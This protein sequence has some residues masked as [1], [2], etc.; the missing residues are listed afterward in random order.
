MGYHKV[1][2]TK[3]IMGEYSKVKEEMQEL[4]DAV[5]QGVKVLVIC[6]LCD[7]IGAIEA[8]SQTQ[9]NLSLE[10]LIKMKDLT[11]ESF[12]DGTRK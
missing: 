4:Q 1:S 3:G 12:N 8:Y 6:E 10:D 7:L 11:K 2:V 9:F 5:L